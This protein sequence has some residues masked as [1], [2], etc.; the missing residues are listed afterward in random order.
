M[1]QAEQQSTAYTNPAA[2]WY[3][4]VSE[5][6]QS[7]EGGESPEDEQRAQAVLTEREDA[8]EAL[9]LADCM[10]L[11]TDVDRGNGRR[12]ISVVQPEEGQ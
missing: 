5:Q 2:G 10:G 4:V 7:F 9:T 11:Q 3:Q 6:F 12:M 8:T 1:A